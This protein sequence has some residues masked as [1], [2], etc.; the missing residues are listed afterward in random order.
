MVPPP[1]TARRRGRQPAKPRAWRACGREKAH[2][3]NPRPGPG[4]GIAPKVRQGMDDRANTIA[5]WVLAA[6]I[7]A[8]GTSIV[9]GEYFHAER[10]EEMGYEVQG[11]EQESGGGAAVA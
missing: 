4:A 10:P 6:G 11:V 5:G 1:H 8:L 2:L 9:S 3:R 7:V